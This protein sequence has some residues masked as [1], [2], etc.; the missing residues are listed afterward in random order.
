M[1]VAPP[2]PEKKIFF[3]DEESQK[4]NRLKDQL[5]LYNKST[6]FKNIQKQIMSALKRNNN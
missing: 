4:L 3:N 5:K 2:S 1:V 6:L